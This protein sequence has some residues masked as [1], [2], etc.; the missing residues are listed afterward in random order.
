LQRL[1]VP[2]EML[3][4]PDEGHW[5]LKPQNSQLWYSTVDA[6]CDKWTHTNQQPSAVQQAP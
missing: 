6:W 3:Y 5:V 1:K 2:S 4:F